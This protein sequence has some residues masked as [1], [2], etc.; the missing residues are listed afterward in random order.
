[1]QEGPNCRLPNPRYSNCKSQSQSS[2]IR[3]APMPIKISVTNRRT[4]PLRVEYLCLLDNVAVDSQSRR[5]NLG[6]FSIQ[7]H[8]ASELENLLR[9]RDDPPL[10]EE[11]REL[12]EEWSCLTWAHFDTN[13]YDA[14]GFRS[15]GGSGSDWE[16]N[17]RWFL[18][19]AAI[20]KNN[21]F[22]PFREFIETL[23]LLKPSDGPVIP[24]R[25]FLRPAGDV[26]TE[27]QIV[28]R[29][30]NSYTAR[31]NPED[32]IVTQLIAGFPL[33]IEDAAA[34][35]ELAKQLPTPS[36][37]KDAYIAIA[38]HFFERANDT[39]T[40]CPEGFDATDSLLSYDACIEAL[41]LRESERGE[42]TL[43]NRFCKLIAK[44]CPTWK[45]TRGPS[46]IPK[47]DDF[48]R[49]IFLL[50]S[51]IAHGV[52]PVAKT[53]NLITN[54]CNKGIKNSRDGIPS[55]NYGEVFPEL[56]KGNGYS[57]WPGTS[58]L[59]NVR[60]AAR[61]CLRYFLAERAAG[62]SRS[63]ILKSLDQ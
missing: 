63:E 50:R 20:S 42:K 62:R 46:G 30:V 36:T 2:E 5:V 15:Y 12:F 47:P 60:E 41:L 43:K 56:S 23:N 10:D 24:C 34:F 9:G 11:E 53:A 21:R 48:Y 22:R 6:A 28:S 38:R 25:I 7:R 31:W 35:N 1:M 29:H 40:V 32:E 26:Q 17:R 58:F 51:K 13:A 49:R 57:G 45:L 4:S 39:F 59:V 19:E 3:S 37:S 16:I 27:S 14:S 52:W 55:G 61:L 44:S 54:G 8:T 18:R 33:G